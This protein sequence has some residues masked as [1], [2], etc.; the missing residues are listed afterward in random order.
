MAHRDALEEEGFVCL[1]SA[2]QR[3]EYIWEEFESNF[4]PLAFIFASDHYNHY[5]M[6]S[7]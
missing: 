3:E 4:C 5:H 6:A 1:I 2:W 7:E